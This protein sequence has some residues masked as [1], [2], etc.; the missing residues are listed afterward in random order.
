MTND[1]KGEK[2]ERRQHKRF[3]AKSGTFKS[4]TVEGEIIDISMGGFAFSY[5]DSEEWT[6]ETFDVGMLLGE[7][8]LC[9]EDVPLRIISD[10]A[11]NRGLSMTRRCG[12]KFGKLS[13]KQLAQLEYYIWAN[14]DATE[15]EME[16]DFD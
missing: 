16:N 5:S 15:L 12:V 11:I 13:P 14:T 1:K 3:E 8:D 9:I 10:C 6:N 2:V 4:E 7:K